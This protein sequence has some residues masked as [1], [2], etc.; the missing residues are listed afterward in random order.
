MSWTVYNNSNVVGGSDV[1][2]A[3]TLADCQAACVNVS[4]CTGVD[5][6][7]INSP[8]WRCYAISIIN[9]SINLGVMDGIAHYDLNRDCSLGERCSSMVIYTSEK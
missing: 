1:S 4:T 9:P 3:N 8:G 6:N 2:G 5:F 7:A